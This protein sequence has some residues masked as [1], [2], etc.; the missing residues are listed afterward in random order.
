MWLNLSSLSGH[1]EQVYSSS[2]RVAKRYY[3]RVQGLVKRYP[4]QVY[5]VVF[6]L[7][8]IAAVLGPLAA[9][10]FSDVFPL[11]RLLLGWLTL[12]GGISV[13]IIGFI[14]LLWEDKS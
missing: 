2:K 1:W 10:E 14:I 3:W 8:T 9:R 4:K 13:P 6:V 7:A 11:P 5:L 12:L